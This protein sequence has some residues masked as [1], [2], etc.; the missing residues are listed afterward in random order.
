MKRSMLSFTVLFVVFL[1]ASSAF[2]QIYEENL[3]EPVQ[4]GGKSGESAF[5]EG[6]G[7]ETLLLTGDPIYTSFEVPCE[8]YYDECTTDYRINL[9]DMKGKYTDSGR[10]AYSQPYFANGNCTYG[11]DAGSLPSNKNL[12]PFVANAWGHDTTTSDGGQLYFSITVWEYTGS[13]CT[14]TNTRTAS[15]SPYCTFTS[16]Q[17]MSEVAWADGGAACT[18]S[19]SDPGNC[20]MPDVL[21]SYPGS[22]GTWYYKYKLYTQTC[23]YRGANCTTST[24]YGCFSASWYNP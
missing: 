8:L 23:D 9:G 3:M 17:T 1:F 10:T 14:G 5:I 13:G 16:A 20:H 19:Y 22:T 24:A 12:V 11:T 6:G 18:G 4:N 15:D 7:I 2:A 21:I